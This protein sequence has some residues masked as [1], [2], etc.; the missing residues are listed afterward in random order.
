MNDSKP[1]VGRMESGSEEGDLTI[2]KAIQDLGRDIQ[3]LK[4]ELKQEWPDFRNELGTFK[5][6][7]NQ[8]LQS[9]V[10]DVCNQGTKL[11]EAEQRVE[12][13]E[14]ANTELKDAL[15]Y[16]LKQQ[17]LL[18]VKV[19]DLE[20]KSCRNNIRIYCIKGGA[21]RKINANFY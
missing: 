17:G 10:R 3:N 9:I 8:N 12:E 15:L 4:T 7:I 1:S 16:S 19:T 5:T 20:G 14:T 21:E 6:E 11:T 18:Q 13:T 2:A